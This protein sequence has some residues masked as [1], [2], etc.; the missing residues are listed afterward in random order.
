ML[1]KP[2]HTDHYL[3]LDFN[4]PLQEKSSVGQTL[5]H[6]AHASITYEEDKLAEFQHIVK[7]LGFLVTKN[8]LK[9]YEP[10]ERL[11]G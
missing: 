3:S 8:Q 2:P 6:Q 7:V 4:H 5:K 9:K 10:E 11:I 1:H